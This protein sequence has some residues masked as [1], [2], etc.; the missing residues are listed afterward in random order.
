M[1]GIMVTICTTGLENQNS[2]TSHSLP[3]IHKEEDVFTL[4]ATD[5]HDKLLRDHHNVRPMQVN[6]Q[7]RIA[8]V[9]QIFRVAS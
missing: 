9:L 6:I 3:A 5:E 4:T 7:K 8:T 2:A 1:N